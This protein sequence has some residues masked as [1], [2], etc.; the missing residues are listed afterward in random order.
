MRKLFFVLAMLL[1]GTAQAVEETATNRLTGFDTVFDSDADH[2]AQVIKATKGNLY[3]LTVDNADLA[4]KI[5][6]QL[7]D[8][9]TSDVI[10]GTTT[11][12]YVIPVPAGAMFDDRFLPP[13]SFKT[14]ITYAV[15]QTT[16]SG[17]VTEII[18]LSAGYK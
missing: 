5:Y 1:C 15:T 17:D 18:T 4:S 12:V 8:D 6:I 13:M 16:T 11:P 3:S 14:A 10:V 7:F 9:T 2:T